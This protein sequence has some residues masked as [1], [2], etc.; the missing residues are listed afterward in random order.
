MVKTRENTGMEADES[1]KQKKVIAEARNEATTV[2]FGS[3]MDLC[4]LENSELKPQIQNYKGRVVFC[5]DIVKDDSGSYAVITEQGSGSSVSQMTAAKVMDVMDKQQMQC[6]LTPPS[7]WKMHH[8]CFKNS[9]V[10]MSRYLD[11]ST[12]TQMA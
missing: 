2:H 7:K 1:Q 8:H 3:L 5:G 12:N 4:H 11:T 6:Q 10:R 9:E